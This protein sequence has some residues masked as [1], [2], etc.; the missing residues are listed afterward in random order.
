MKDYIN[1][2][3]I[4]GRKFSAQSNAV[5]TATSFRK[6]C[7]HLIFFRGRWGG[8]EERKLISVSP[9]VH[10]CIFNFFILFVQ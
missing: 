6:I 10:P 4:L 8:E 7:A 3:A 9:D 2:S 1:G 5:N